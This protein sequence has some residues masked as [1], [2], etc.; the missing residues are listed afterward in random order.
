MANTKKT[1]AKKT[2]AKKIYTCRTCGK[3]TTEKKHL[4]NP[5]DACGRVAISRN[6]LC[7]PKTIK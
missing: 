3:T 2:P 6:S 4:C 5:C 1:T 7:N